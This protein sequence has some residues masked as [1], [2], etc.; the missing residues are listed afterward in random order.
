[1][2]DPRELNLAGKDFFSEIEAAHY[3][4]VS[5]AQFQQS[6]EA[7]L[8]AGVKAR[9]SLGK[10]VYLRSE[11]ARMIENAPAWSRSADGSLSAAA[12]PLAERMLV[13]FRGNL[14]NKRIRPYKPR[15]KRKPDSTE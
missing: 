11:L 13:A 9:R 8:A 15:T 12:P 2:R 4:C 7:L 10:K 1:M 6:T 14:T 5:S 3:C